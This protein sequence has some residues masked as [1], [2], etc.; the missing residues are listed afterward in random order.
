MENK[1]WELTDEVLLKLLIDVN[2]NNCNRSETFCMATM[3][4]VTHAA[5]KKMLEYLFQ[6]D[7][8]SRL[9]TIDEA[10][11]YGGYEFTERI[12]HLLAEFG[13]GENND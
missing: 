5:Q 7:K 9:W 4:S 10:L 3:S 6:Q 13:I 12:D 1:P 2:A 11:F 8:P